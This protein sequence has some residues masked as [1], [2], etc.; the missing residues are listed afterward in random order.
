VDTDG[1]TVIDVSYPFSRQPF[2]PSVVD[3]HV[4]RTAE[5]IRRRMPEIPDVTLRGQ[6]LQALYV[7]Q[8]APTVTRVLGAQVGRTWLRREETNSGSARWTV[9]DRAGRVESEVQLPASAE[10]LWAKGA[11]VYA[12]VTT[13][14]N[15]PDI[16]RYR[17][18]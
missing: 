13:E 10:V 1:R 4:S 8:Y 3:A 2:P 12:A 14:G 18:R 16:G 11:V 15:A 17:L 5:T 7:P 6:L 9:L